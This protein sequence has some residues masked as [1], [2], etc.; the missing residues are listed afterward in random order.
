MAPGSD[1]SVDMRASRWSVPWPRRSLL[2]FAAGIAGGGL[3]RA[4]AQE[5]EEPE[6]PRVVRQRERR[7]RRSV[8]PDPNAEPAMYPDLRILPL[9]DLQFD[10]LE[11]GTHVLRF[12]AEIWNAGEGPIELSAPTSDESGEAGALYQNL[13]DAAVGGKLAERR[14]VDGRLIYHAA[15]EHYHFADFARYE[16]LDCNEPDEC[17]PI[18]LGAKVSFCLIDSELEDLD[19]PYPRQYTVCESTLQGITP[20]YSDLYLWSLPEQ[21][22]VLPDDP[23]ADGEYAVRVTADPDK[24]LDEGGDERE[25]KNA[26]TTYF[27]VSDG[28]IGNVR[29]TREIQR[30]AATPGPIVTS[31]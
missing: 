10:R 16:L 26:V 3:A 31:P 8:Q 22:V 7:E 20:G 15:H 29:E 9:R 19:V 13:Y 23:L 4:F 27:T 2:R 21:W 18:G 25:A 6:D 11:D 28:E 14:Q 12:T 24:L 30:A 17:L 1:E 5:D